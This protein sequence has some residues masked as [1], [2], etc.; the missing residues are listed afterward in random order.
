MR[1]SRA[2]RVLSQY[3]PLVLQLT[4]SFPRD[5]R[6]DLAQAARL[7]LLEVAN[8]GPESFDAA[9][10]IRAAIAA[11]PREPLIAVIDP[12]TFAA[13]TLVDD[14]HLDEPDT[15]ALA[16]ETYAARIAP[17]LVRLPAVERAVIELHY[18]DG[19][20]GVK[21]ARHLGISQPAVWHRLQNA[22]KRLAIYA[23][24]PAF[25]ADHLRATLTGIFTWPRSQHSDATR[26]QVLVRYYGTPSI[27]ETARAL[28]VS[29]SMVRRT[30]AS[31]VEQLADLAAEDAELAEVHGALTCLVQHS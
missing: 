25:T 31:A 5:L 2:A 19:M 6:E 24:M 8:D 17:H 15:S 21:L 3:E 9:R 10:V 22:C 13:P 28:G 30:I 12:D 20:N 23:G 1:D 18:R 11:T 27:P 4:R 26:V 14:T 29:V 16:R 7:A